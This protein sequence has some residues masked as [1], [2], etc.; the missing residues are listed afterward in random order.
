MEAGRK[1]KGGEKI[2]AEAFP[3]GTRGKRGQEVGNNWFLP[4]SLPSLN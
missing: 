4:P 2:M 1:K 3:V